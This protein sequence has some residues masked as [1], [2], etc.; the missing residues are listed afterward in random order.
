MTD[1][2]ID[3]F[4]KRVILYN[5]P[6]IAVPVAEYELLKEKAAKYDKLNE[7]LEVLRIQH[8]DI[9]TQKFV[10]HHE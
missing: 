7:V 1:Q 5:V 9:R 8:N 2:Q 10:G 4:R 6:A 3:K